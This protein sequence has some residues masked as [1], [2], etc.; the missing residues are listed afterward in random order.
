[1]NCCQIRW[2]L[3]SAQ[4]LGSDQATPQNSGSAPWLYSRCSAGG[5]APRSKPILTVVPDGEDSTRKGM[6]WTRQSRDTIWSPRPRWGASAAADPSSKPARTLSGMPPPTSRIS[7]SRPSAATRTLAATLCRKTLPMRFERTV[8]TTASLNRVLLSDG[9]DTWRQTRRRGSGHS[10]SA[11]AARSAE[12]ATG[13]A[14]GISLAP[15]ARGE[16]GGP[17]TAPFA[18]PPPPPFGSASTAFQVAR[19]WTQS[20]LPSS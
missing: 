20:A 13:P 9:I 17:P 2:A 12:A 6:E 10:P 16:A 3:P 4:C 11:P 5:P 19:H 7:T 15:R 8:E 14:R 1:V 18:S